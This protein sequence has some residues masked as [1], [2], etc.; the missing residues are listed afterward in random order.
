M[1]DGK[2]CMSPMD[3]AKDVTNNDYA[4]FRNTQAQVNNYTFG[5]GV[6]QKAIRCKYTCDIA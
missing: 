1:T 6:A 3:W 4:T 2:I 5:G